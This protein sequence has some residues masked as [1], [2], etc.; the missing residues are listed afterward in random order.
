MEEELF[1]K[2]KIFSIKTQIGKEQNVAE[3]IRG[4]IKKTHDKNVLS[5]LVTPELRGYVFVEAY[6]ADEVRKMIRTISYVRGMLDGNIPIDEIERFLVP[7]SSVEKITEGDIVEMI[8]GPF[9]GEMAKV[10]HIDKSKEEITVEL[11]DS[12]VPIPITVR[13]D[14]VRV[15]RRKEE[16]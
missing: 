5:V 1:E 6:K 12:V 4:R 13:G 9:K 3:L 10:T 2:P 11:F 16:E 7:A 14:Q 15:V 8:S